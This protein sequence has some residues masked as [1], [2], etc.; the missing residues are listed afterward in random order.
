MGTL[1]LETENLHFSYETHLPVL[2][3]IN[4]QIARGDKIALLGAN[5]SGKSTLLMNLNGSLTSGAGVIRIAGKPVSPG[6]KGREELR[7]NAGILFQDPDDQLFSTSIYE[8]ISFG[9]SCAGLEKEEIDR[10]VREALEIFELT[11]LRDR[12]VHQ[13]SFGQKK[14]AALAGLFVMQTPLVLLDEPGAGLDP[15]S[16]DT[17]LR[18][19]E[20]WHGRGSTIVIATHDLEFAFSWSDTTILMEDGRILSRDGRGELFNAP[21]LLDQARL[22]LPLPLRLDRA[23]KRHSGERFSHPLPDSLEGLLEMLE[24]E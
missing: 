7:S 12:P 8:D 6:R 16:Y 2:K 14:R 21:H 3:G 10:R 18:T 13:L 1:L 5:G 9:P 15:R 4:L 17:L 22:T 20:I 23:L 19:L 11:D 24:G